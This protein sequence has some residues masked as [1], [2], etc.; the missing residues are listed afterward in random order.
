MAT[1]LLPVLPPIPLTPTKD[2]ASVLLT[3][4]KAVAV[5]WAATL[6]A[7]PAQY[8]A[9]Q[10]A[11]KAISQV[12]STASHAQPIVCPALQLATVRSA[13]QDTMLIMEF[14]KPSAHLM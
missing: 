8:P 1:A 7:P 10:L 3:P 9:A 4:T 2:N 14:A 13:T 5:A 11:I 6:S 12:E